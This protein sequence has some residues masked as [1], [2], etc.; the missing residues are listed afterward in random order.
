MNG[1]K[2]NN[3][4]SKIDVNNN[5]SFSEFKLKMLLFELIYEKEINENSIIIIDKILSKL[6]PVYEANFYLKILKYNNQSDRNSIINEYANGEYDNKMFCRKGMKTFWEI[7]AKILHKRGFPLVEDVIYDIFEW[8]QDLNWPGSDEIIDL[9]LV[10][11]NEV[12]INGIQYSI[13]QAIQSND[14]EWLLN[15]H[16]V[17]DKKVDIK[18]LT[19]QELYNKAVDFEM[20]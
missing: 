17:F 12:F 8:L 16:D 10:A 7:E 20:R 6:Y 1:R 3:K 2:F 4:L 9:L 14:D 5:D 19:W 15:I 13:K 11:P 18:N